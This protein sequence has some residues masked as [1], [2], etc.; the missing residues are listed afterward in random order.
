MFSIDCVRRLSGF[1]FIVG[2]ISTSLACSI[3]SFKN[4]AEI[5]V[6]V[7]EPARIRFSGK[8]AG[9]GMML[10]SSMG[11]MGIAIG[12]AIDEGIGKEINETAVQGGFTIEKILVDAF[13]AADKDLTIT[14]KRY[15]FVLARGDFPE[16]S[17]FPELDLEIQMANAEPV[18]Y[19]FPGAVEGVNADEKLQ[20][21]SLEQLKTHP[22][23]VIT[24]FEYAAQKLAGLAKFPI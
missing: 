12:V 6:Q 24:A 17:V 4:K 8:G 2:L 23:S 7:D 20:V 10:S 21:W 18:S 11:P 5:I 15:G 9:A 14:V 13:Q 1:V 16:D 19:R 22:E 3:V